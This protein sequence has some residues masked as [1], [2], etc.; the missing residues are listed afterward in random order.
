[1]DAAV[2]ELLAL[3]ASYK[4]STGVDWT[5][6]AAPPAKAPAASSAPAQKSEATKSS[7]NPQELHEKIKA[8]GDSVRELKAKKADK[9]L[10]I[11]SSMSS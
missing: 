2:K 9:V 6:S 10:V 4:A 11:H 1:M 3:K 7:S 8:C 5:P